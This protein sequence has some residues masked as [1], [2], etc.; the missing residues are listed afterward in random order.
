MSETFPIIKLPK[1]GIILFDL[2]EKL[3][4]KVWEPQVTKIGISFKV[5][6]RRKLKKFRLIEFYARQCD[7]CGNPGLLILE[8]NGKRFEFGY[9]Y[10]CLEWVKPEQFACL[11]EKSV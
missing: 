10:G 11:F 1:D 2:N 8:K 5:G 9:E 4:R 6:K 7:C 3:D